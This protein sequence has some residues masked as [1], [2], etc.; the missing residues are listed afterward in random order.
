MF[1][2]KYFAN[3]MGCHESRIDDNDYDLRE[4]MGILDFIKEEVLKMDNKNQCIHFQ[5]TWEQGDHPMEET[6]A[7]QFS[8]RLEGKKM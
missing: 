4:M 1:D 3:Q 6:P 5:E 8:H 7:V 2:V